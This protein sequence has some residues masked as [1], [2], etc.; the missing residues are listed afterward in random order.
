MAKL[1]TRG[2]RN[3]VKTGL[4]LEVVHPVLELDSKSSQ[5]CA[6]MPVLDVLDATREIRQLPDR[7]HFPILAMMASAFIEDKT[8]CIGARMYD[9]IAKP[10]SPELLYKA[11]MQWLGQSFGKTR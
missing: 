7:Q 10:V 5:R 1:E 3:S 6:S 2:G 8:R 4:G 11:L 9:F